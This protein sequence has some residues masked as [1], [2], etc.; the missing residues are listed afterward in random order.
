MVIDGTNPRR[1]G[2]PFDLSAERRVGPAHLRYWSAPRKRVARSGFA[3]KTSAAPTDFLRLRLLE[4]ASD[5]TAARTESLHFE[6]GRSCLE[7]RAG[8]HARRT[9]SRSG[10]A[11]ARRSASKPTTRYGARPSGRAQGSTT[12]PGSWRSASTRPRA[13]ARAWS[14]SWSGWRTCW[15]PTRCWRAPSRRPRLT[16]GCRGPQA[17]RTERGIPPPK[18]APQCQQS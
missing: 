18:R 3:V 12:S 16:T 11:S 17:E 6:H 15:R 2:A 9:R 7:H 14:P 4:T 5:R 8:V 13:R 1:S 10:A